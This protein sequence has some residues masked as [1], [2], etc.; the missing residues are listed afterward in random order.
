MKF[1][2]HSLALAIALSLPLAF[3]SPAR[4]QSEPSIDQVYQAAN[5]GRLAEADKM[6]EQVLANHPNSAKAHFVKAELAA[7]ESNAAVARAELAKAEKI[8]PGLPFAKPEA[9]QAL[10]AEVSSSGSLQSTPSSRQSERMTAAPAPSSQGQF[11]LATIAVVFALIAG[12]IYL[13]VRRR[14]PAPD[15]PAAATYAGG[16]VQ[17]MGTGMPAGVPPGMQQGYGPGYPAAGYPQQPQPG[18]GST[19]GRGLATGL[20]VGAGVVAAQEIGHRL[21]DQHG[22]PMPSSQTGALPESERGLLDPGVNPDMGGQDFGIN[23]AGD[24]D[25]GGGSDVTGGDWDT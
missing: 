14:N 2:R 11:P 21:F 20:A 18:M 12:G 15:L 3:V 4:G 23:D 22:Q 7:R 17:P 10:R 25:Q 19:L 5:A 1:S 16:P 13:L 9:V 24:W 6:I 8:A